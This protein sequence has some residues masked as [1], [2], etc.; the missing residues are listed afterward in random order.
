MKKFLNFFVI[1]TTSLSLLACTY[2]PVV[3]QNEKFFQVGQDQA[4]ADIDKCMKDGDAYLK[5]Y[6]TTH[7]LKSTGR[8]AAIGGFIGVVFGLLGR[9]NLSSVATST[10][11][12]AGIGGAAGGLGAAASG[13]VTPDQ[14]KQRYV[15]NCLNR[16]GYEV[17]GWQ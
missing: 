3:D 10:A 14:I 13:S 7:V 15:N 4:E 16:K 6:K 2:K 17:L 11:V 8:G 1:I 5:Q 9:G 12:G